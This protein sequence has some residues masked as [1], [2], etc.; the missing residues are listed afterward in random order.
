MNSIPSDTFDGKPDENF[1]IT[2]VEQGTPFIFKPDSL[3]P[4]T[5]S[6]NPNAAPHPNGHPP[7]PLTNLDGAT[8]KGGQRS[9]SPGKHSIALSVSCQGRLRRRREEEEGPHRCVCCPPRRN[10]HLRRPTTGVVTAA[11]KPR[12]KPPPV[13]LQVTLVKQVGAGRRW[14]SGAFLKTLVCWKIAE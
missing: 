1:K 14:S 7:T 10:S 6:S 4:P 9:R 5:S 2:F 3:S 12:L 8:D 13:L 11:V